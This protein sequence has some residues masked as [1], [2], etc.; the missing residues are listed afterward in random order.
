MRRTFLLIAVFLLSNT[1]TRASLA[2]FRSE[3]QVDH[4]IIKE[5]I[6]FEG[7]RG[8]QT[9]EMI[10]S[11]HFW[12]GVNLLDDVPYQ[13]SCQCGLQILSQ[14]SDQAR[15]NKN[16]NM[17]GV[18]YQIQYCFQI[19]DMRGADGDMGYTVPIGSSDSVPFM[20]KGI[21]EVATKQDLNLF[22]VYP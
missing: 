1:A 13:T 11:S 17:L 21:S 2:F 4:S 16:L 12:L 19:L 3:M 14:F 20:F 7:D 5:A 6:L 9:S 8:R 18:L 22:R 15:L 10:L